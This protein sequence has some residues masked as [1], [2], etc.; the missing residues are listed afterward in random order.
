MIKIILLICMLVLSGCSSQ[1]EEL[2]QDIVERDS[3]IEFLECE[4][5]I[6]GDTWRESDCGL[7]ISREQ[8][9]FPCKRGL[10]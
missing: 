6:Y 3:Y 1:V 2:K 4:A 7:Q 9:E 10:E 5:D 8:E